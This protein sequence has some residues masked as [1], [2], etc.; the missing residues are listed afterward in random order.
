MTVIYRVHFLD[1]AVRDLARLDKPIAR[2]VINVRD[3]P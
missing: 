1:A 3:R 2:R